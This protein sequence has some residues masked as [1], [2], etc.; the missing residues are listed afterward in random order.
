MQVRE[1]M[2]ASVECA[3][4]DDTIASVA[5]KMRDMDFGVMPVCGEND[6]I[7]GMITDRDITTRATA[8]CC[9][10]AETAVRDVMT[11]NVIYCHDDQDVDEAADLMKR[12]QIRRLLVL[13]R[14]K[15]LVGI[16]SL[17]DLAIQTD[18]EEM[19]GA[20]L[21]AVSEPTAQR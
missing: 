9:N 19:A 14:N 12:H 8:G 5:L 1:V 13:D 16:V 7:L 4:P 10:P 18:D 6:R 21:E 20:T 15:K 3:R 2:T 11:A 17:G